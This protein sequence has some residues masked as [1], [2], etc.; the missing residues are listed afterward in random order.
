MRYVKHHK[1]SKLQPT[2]REERL[3]RLMYTGVWKL[4]LCEQKPETTEAGLLALIIIFFE[5]VQ[6]W[7][8]P[9]LC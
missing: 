8:G 9:G 5:V 7:V 3:L 1:L 6:P 4:A 2:F